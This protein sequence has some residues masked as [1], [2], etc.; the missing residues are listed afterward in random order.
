MSELFW[1]HAPFLL[2][3]ARRLHSGQGDPEVSVSRC[4]E[5]VWRSADH[6]E[7]RGTLRSWLYRILY[8]LVMSE[9]GKKIYAHHHVREDEGGLASEVGPDS[10]NPDARLIE[11]AEL[12]ERKGLVE[13]LLHAIDDA[14]AK[15]AVHLRFGSAMSEKE[16]MEAMDIPR[17]R[18]VY[19]I[20]KARKSML[21]KLLEVDPGLGRRVQAEVDAKA[22][23]RA[24]RRREKRVTAGGERTPTPVA[25]KPE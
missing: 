24:E 3:A 16:V 6:Y 12:L 1:R 4:F 10:M 18:L 11:S 17:S 23:K 20:R 8:N 25:L 14:E 21:A 7:P 5:R 2:A 22:M 19:L 13:A 9:R 15:E